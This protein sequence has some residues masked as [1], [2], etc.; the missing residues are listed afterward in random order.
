MNKHTATAEGETFTRNSK[1]H[2]YTHLVV[3]GCFGD[4][5]E[6]KACYWCDERLPGSTRIHT[7]GWSSR[8]DLAE[9]NAA[10]MRARGWTNVRVIPVTM[11]TR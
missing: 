10:T 8:P 9:K 2:T 1:T 5:A 7:L 4:D 3:S 11:E 6:K